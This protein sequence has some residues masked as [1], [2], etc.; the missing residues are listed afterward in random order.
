MP[1][2]ADSPVVTTLLAI[3]AGAVCVFGFAPTGLWWLPLLSLALLFHL[4]RRYPARGAWLG[5]CYGMG[6]FASG[7]SWLYTSLHEYGGMSAWLATLA[8]A[9]F[10]AFLALFPALAG[11]LAA[12]TFWRAPLLLAAGWVLQEWVRSWVFTGFPWLLLGYSQVPASPLAGYDPIGGVFLLSLLTAWSA[13]TLQ[14]PTRLS[15]SAL[16]A[17]WIAGLGLQQVHWTHPDTAPLTVSLLQGDI[18]QDVKWQPEHL[19]STLERYERM[20]LAS[21]AQLVV[22]PET[23]FPLLY[24]QIPPVYLQVLA[25]SARMRQADIL[26]GIPERDRQGHYFNS[27]Y[28][29]G[30]SPLQIYRKHHLV[31]FGEYVP[32]QSLFGS[33]LQLLQVPMADFS[34][35]SAFQPP[36]RVDGLRV[37]PDICYEDVFGNE[38]I[39]ALPQASLLIN[40]TNDAW[41]GRSAAPWQHAQMSQARALE[42]GRYMLRATNTGL[43]AIITPDGRLAATLPL[44][45]AATLDGQVR[46]YTGTTPYVRFGDTPVLALAALL[47]GSAFWRARRSPPANRA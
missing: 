21:H 41:F 34:R 47:L 1:L 44:F 5:W 33:L 30:T 40:I 35:G 10:S 26:V 38:I 9:L 15:L 18:A 11:W 43:T 14:A 28:S 20:V 4:W 22:L 29:L 27:L 24:D 8:V 31:P 39:H 3:L 42:T 16:V 13:A 45:T 37:A 36:L 25:D 12:R 7:I 19:T 46:G 32:L 17:L 2:R 6:Y 23:A